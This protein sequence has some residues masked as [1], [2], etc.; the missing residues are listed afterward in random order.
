MASKLQIVIFI[1]ILSMIDAKRCNSCCS[2]SSANSRAN[3]YKND[4]DKSS[5]ENR[6]LKS[7]T[8]TLGDN[9]ALR[10]STKDG[11]S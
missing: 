9:F 11:V 8:I 10:V 5:Q 7:K 2:C 4:L 1:L 6:M 3:K